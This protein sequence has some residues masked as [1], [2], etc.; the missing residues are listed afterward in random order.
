MGFADAV[1]ACLSRYVTFRGR[2]RRSEFWWFALFVSAGGLVL[3]LVDFVLFDGFAILSP[4]FSLAMLL[5]NLA[6]GVRRLHDIGRTGWW[7]LIALVPLIGTLVLIFF[8]VQDSEAGA[9][10]HGPS[11]KALPEPEPEPEPTA[12]SG[13]PS[14]SRDRGSSD[15]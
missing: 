4:L 15:A 9:N 14:V 6:V 5:P 3:N 8:W 12:A 2:A 13:V 10:R 1:R 7:M 11:P